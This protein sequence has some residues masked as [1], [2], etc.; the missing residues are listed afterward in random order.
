M[1]SSPVL[2]AAECDTMHDGTCALSQRGINIHSTECCQMQVHIAKAAMRPE[3]FMPTC[4]PLLHA[5]VPAMLQHCKRRA[6]HASMLSA[7]VA[8]HARASAAPRLLP[9]APRAVQH[10]LSAR[11]RTSSRRTFCPPAIT[12]PCFVT[13]RRFASDEGLCGGPQKPR[14]GLER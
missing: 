3:E 10:V 9:A 11:S 8:A 7:Q 14:M 12:C 5:S 4:R 2:D 1:H 13:E 6:L